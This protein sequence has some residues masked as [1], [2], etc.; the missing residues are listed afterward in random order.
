VIGRE[1][2]KQAL[3]LI[4]RRR[5]DTWWW[6]SGAGRPLPS[7]MA[8]AA[9]APAA[10][11]LAAAVAPVALQLGAAAAPTSAAARVAT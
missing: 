10:L 8:A 11:L 3:D 4:I 5:A 7:R 6:S 2:V 9:M 1:D